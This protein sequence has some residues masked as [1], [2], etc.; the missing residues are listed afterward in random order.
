MK[1]TPHTTKGER[2]KKKMEATIHRTRCNVADDQI[3]K[4]IEIHD[5][6]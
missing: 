3:K 4:K 5:R 1:N 2:E 6:Y